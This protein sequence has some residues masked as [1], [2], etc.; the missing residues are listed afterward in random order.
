MMWLAFLV[1]LTA[2]PA[3]GG[4]LPYVAQRIYHVD[5]TGSAGWWPASRSAACS[6][7]SAWCS[8]A[9]PRHPE[10]STLV[11]T[12]VWYALLL[13]FGH[14]TTMGAGLAR[15]PRAG[16]AQNVAMISMT[17]TLLARR[18]RRFRGRVM[19]VRTLAVYGLPLGLMAAG[20][21]IER[22]GYPAHHHRLQ[23]DR[24]RPHRPDRREVAREHVGARARASPGPIGRR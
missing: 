20:V 22:I 24:A 9:G 12:A 10:R 7:R 5:A 19:G 14:V 4:L 15:A 2:Y 18:R 6:A 21:L 1:N 16:F 3:S 11:S 8:R 17:A 13:V 23:R